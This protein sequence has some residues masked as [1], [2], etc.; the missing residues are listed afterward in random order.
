MTKVLIPLLVVA[1]CVV[2][3]C[4]SKDEPKGVSSSVKSE[5]SKE[6]REYREVLTQIIDIHMK[7]GKIIPQDEI[8]KAIKEFKAAT[9]EK[10]AEILKGV[11]HKLERNKQGKEL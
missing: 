7:A 9:P 1:A 2:A 11:Q 6:E 8:E 3:G 4:G 10:Q 5:M